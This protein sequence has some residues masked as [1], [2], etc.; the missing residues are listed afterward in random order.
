MQG[1]DFGSRRFRV[2]AGARAIEILVDHA[3]TGAAHQRHKRRACGSCFSRNDRCYKV[4]RVVKLSELFGYK[5][6]STLIRN[7]VFTNCI[8]NTAKRIPTLI[9]KVSSLN[10][11]GFSLSLQSF[12]ANRDATPV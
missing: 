3:G 1:K 8:D 7:R 10:L 11:T 12:L 6:F 5:G 2:S 9:L 4:A